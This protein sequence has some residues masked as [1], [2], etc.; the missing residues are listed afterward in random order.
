[1]QLELSTSNLISA[2]EEYLRRYKKI[3]EE[4]NIKDLKFG[5]FPRHGTKW[6]EMWAND[7][8]P[9]EITLDE[10][11]TILEFNGKS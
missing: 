6:L 3:P 10:E 1:M 7:L 5:P 9:I 8:I 2:I 11:V 4:Q